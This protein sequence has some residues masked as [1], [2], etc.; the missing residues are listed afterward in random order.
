MTSRRRRR[1]TEVGFEE[2]LLVIKTDMKN[3]PLRIETNIE[4]LFVVPFFLALVLFCDSCV[5][6]QAKT[7][8]ATNA[9]DDFDARSLSERAQLI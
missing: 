6:F 7:V 2:H 5:R 4:K 3:Q 8:S 1:E 9:A